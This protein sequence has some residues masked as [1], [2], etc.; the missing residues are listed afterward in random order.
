[1]EGD[2]SPLIRPI[3]R[4][5][6]HRICAGQVIL[7]LSSAIKELVENSLDAGATSIEINLRDYGEDYFQ[8]IDNGCG[9]SPSNFKVTISDE[10][11]K[12]L[13]PMYTQFPDSSCLR[14]SRLSTILRSWRI[15]QIFRV[16]LRL[17]SEEKLWALYVPWGISR[18]RREQRTSKLLRSW[19]L[20]IPVCW[21][22]R[23]SL[24]AKLV[25]LSLWGSCSPIYL[26]EAKSLNAIYAKSMGSLFLYW[27]WV[28]ILITFIYDLLFGLLD[29]L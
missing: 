11:L 1:M 8:V 23:R 20:I 3:N 27:M 19:P 15:S 10:L 4:A 14:F 17:V 16:W 29:L 25:P 24:H 18:W 22:L 7:D 28:S 2:S 12:K 9:I 6:V 21:L 5:V 13:N 26:F